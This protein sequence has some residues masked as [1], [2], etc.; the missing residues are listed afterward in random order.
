MPQT[1]SISLYEFKEL[2]ETIQD[3]IISAYVQDLPGWW[4][5]DIEERIKNEAKALGIQDFDFV[6]SGFWSQGDGLSFTGT[7]EF[8]AWLDILCQRFP[9]WAK[10]PTNEK[11]LGLQ[12]LDLS[13]YDVLSLQKEDKVNWGDC[14]I[15]RYG[16]MYCHENTVNV[17]APDTEIIGDDKATLNMAISFDGRV[18]DCLNDWKNEL[19]QK[20]YSELQEAYEAYTSRENII[21]DIT[22]REL[23][24]TSSGTI[25]D[26]GE[27]F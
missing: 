20:W 9:E 6:W 14:R 24:Y 5:D 18:Q 23:L 27:L 8:K 21:E 1:K 3:N 12:K 11:S 25:I 10:L 15:H 4:S 2:D 13:L 17:L 22:Q 26:N 19:C 7:L 16:H